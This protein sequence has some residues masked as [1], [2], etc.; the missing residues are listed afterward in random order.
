MAINQGQSTS[1]FQLSWT[2]AITGSGENSVQAEQFSIFSIFFPCVFIQ[3][4]LILLPYH[5]DLAVQCVK[6]RCKARGEKTNV[7]PKLLEKCCLK[8]GKCIYQCSAIKIKVAFSTKM[9]KTVIAKMRS[10][11][12]L[13]VFKVLWGL[14]F[15]Q[16]TKCQ[17]FPDW[18]S[19]LSLDWTRNIKLS[20]QCIRYAHSQC[21]LVLLQAICK[22]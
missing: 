10:S 2:A 21:I 3:L 18:K 22:D 17:S 4:P 6:K 20:A 19:D 15:L 9:N 7:S 1:W 5:H 11:L 16:T 8:A 13:I 12:I 14:C